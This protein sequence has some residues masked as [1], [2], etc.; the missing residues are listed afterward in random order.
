METAARCRSLR[1]LLSDDALV[2]LRTELAL[3]ERSLGQAQAELSGEDSG[4]AHAWL[5]EA[6]ARSDGV[7]RSLSRLAR[8]AMVAGL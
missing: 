7:S 1:D 2:A 6:R 8:D 3:I 5:L 4:S